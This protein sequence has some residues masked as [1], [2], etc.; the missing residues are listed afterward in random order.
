M[1]TPAITVDGVTKVFT[2]YKHLQTSVK[3]VLLHPAQALRRARPSRFVALEGVD[4][5]V[6]AGEAHGLIGPNGAGKS[7]LLGIIGG[8]IHPT[9]G[10]VTTRARVSPLLE[11][12]VGFVPDL[13]GEENA[14]LNGVLLGL[15]RCRVEEKLEAIFDFAEL[16]AFRA[17]ELR[18]YSSGMRSRLGFSVAVHADPEILLVDEVL[19]VG[20]VR[21]RRKCF[22]RIAELR[23]AG[24]TIL[25]VSHDLD[26]V[27]DVCDRATW[28][29]GGR[30]VRTGPVR[31]VVRAYEK[32]MG[33]AAAAQGLQALAAPPKE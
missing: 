19:A 7:T 15:R 30:V 25:F 12:G 28:L 10:R 5:E 17:H 27:I 16:D 1:S 8:V 11:L 13:S 26:T 20:D 6:G 4:L 9:E 3:Q 2:P 21:F 32:A 22:D 31:E 33:G 23:R 24:V 18:T 29:D 14:V